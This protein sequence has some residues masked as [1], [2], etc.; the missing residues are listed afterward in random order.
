MTGAALGPHELGTLVGLVQSG[1]LREAEEQA[2]ALLQSHAG[3]GMVWKILSVALVQQGKNALPALRKTAELLPGDPEAHANLG[4]ALLAVGQSAEA[5]A[6]LER[7]LQLRPQDVDSLLEAAEAAQRIGRVDAAVDFYQRALA[8]DPG[9]REARNNLGNALLQLGRLQEA[10]ACYRLALEARPEDAQVLS[11]L[12]NALRQLGQ[13]REAVSC[14][15]RA[16]ALDPQLF[17]AHSVLGSCLAALDQPERAIACLQRALALDPRSI[18]AHINLA[19]VL[20]QQGKRAEAL[21]LY[22]Q[23]VELDPQRA[24]SH[25]ALGMALFELRRLGEAASSHRRALQLRPGYPFAQVSLAATLRL[26]GR[27]REAEASCQ[28]ALAAAPNDVDALV[29]LGELRADRGR[30]AEA[31]ALFER[32]LRLDARCWSAYCSIAAHRRMTREDPAWLAGVRALLEQPLPVTQRA[33]LQYALGKYHDDI[34]EHDNAFAHYR[35]ANELTQRASTIYDGAQLTAQVDRLITRFD[36]STIRALQSSASDSTLPVF[37]IGMPRSGT[38]LVEQILASHPQVLGA[39]ELRFWLGA[40][41]ALEKAPSEPEAVGRLI[42]DFARDYLA[43]LAELPGYAAARATRVINK[44]PAN[45]LYAGLIHASFPHAKIIHLQRHPLDT[46]VSIYFQNFVSVSPYAND[47]EHLA[48]YYGEYLRIMRH[49]RAVLPPTALL[50]VPYEGLVSDQE[51][52]SRR[53]VDF[54]GLPWDP[55]CLSFHETE[56]VVLTASRWQVRQKIHRGSVG[57]WR[58]YE[59]HLGPLRALLDVIDTGEAGPVATAEPTGA[60]APGSA[61]A[62]SPQT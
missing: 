3:T 54:I 10:V 40:F 41:A 42:A 31:H 30:F 29:L 12:G 43:R 34:A 11:N 1:R 6:S 45:F 7:A 20:R 47:L 46:C 33:A 8:L 26:Q 37:V 27:A 58:H 5:L 53:M 56:R 15:E 61:A 17:M 57:R 21:T 23:A 13:P 9:S 32:A 19:D 16:I 4:S 51:V 25:T 36:A 62:P 28:A 55:A 52:W 18:E 39:G 49:W 60:A 35:E 22:R 2:L 14:S 48:H 50:T 24:E 59:R 44:M 38:S